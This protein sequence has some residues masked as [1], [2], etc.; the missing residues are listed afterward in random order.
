[1]LTG[2]FSSQFRIIIDSF[3]FKGQPYKIGSPATDL[4]AITIICC[5]F[6][7]PCSVLL[8]PAT[9]SC[10]LIL[11]AAENLLHLLFIHFGLLFFVDLMPCSMFGIVQSVMGK[12]NKREANLNKPNTKPLIALKLFLVVRRHFDSKRNQTV[13][14]V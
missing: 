1:M 10:S 8:L 5:Y 6:N 7:K 14:E 9:M 11:F 2:L 4:S 12:A 13:A 3:K